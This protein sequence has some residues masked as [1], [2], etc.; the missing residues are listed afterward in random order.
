M[1]MLALVVSIAAFSQEDDEKTDKFGANKTHFV[2]SYFSLGFMTPPVEGEGAD[3][4]Y[5][6]SHIFT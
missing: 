3:I 4:L 6:K 1:I 2:H 5:G